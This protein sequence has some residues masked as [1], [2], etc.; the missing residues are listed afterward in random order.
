MTTFV[1]PTALCDAVSVGSGTRVDAFVCIS[2]EVTIGRRCTLH[3]HTVLN[4]VIALADDVVV[5]TGARLL[6]DVRVEPGVIVGPSTVV[7]EQKSRGQQEI[8][9]R[10]LA[11]IG[12]NATIR[13]GVVIGRN[14]V[15][16]SGSVVTVSVPAHAIV[17]GNPASIS[18]YVD[19]V[20]SS[21]A[22][23]RIAAPST[24]DQ[25]TS[26]VRGVSFESLTFAS[27][28]RGSLTATEFSAL[29]FQ[30]RRLFSVFG[31]PSE[32]IRGSH[33]HRTC[34]QLLI[35]SV[36]KV[37][38]LVDDGSVREGIELARPDVGLHIPPMIWGTQWRYSRDAVLLVLASHPYD[39]ADYIRDYEEFLA[40][41]EA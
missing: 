2:S 3:R 28:L 16:E 1:D 40:E 27:D 35:C 15:V 13:P 25:L 22:A 10:T 30:P 41:L 8:V 9:I 32:S 17:S 29:P 14:A 24:P 31:V 20:H 33:A 6:G 5:Q 18:G 21:G 34:S 23:A 4:G 11:T 19:S 7:G 39:P 12:A 36:G 26:T 38:C 37:T